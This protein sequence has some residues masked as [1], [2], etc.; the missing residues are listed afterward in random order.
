MVRIEEDDLDE[1]FLWNYRDFFDCFVSIVV[2]EYGFKVFLEVF[3]VE[4]VKLVEGI[5]NESV[6]WFEL[7]LVI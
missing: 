3:N 1:S 5:I 6:F 2:F 4:F 7:S